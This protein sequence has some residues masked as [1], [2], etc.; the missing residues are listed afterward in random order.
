[1]SYVI[2]SPVR[3]EERHVE[4]TL[5]SVVGQTVRPALWLLVDD[6]ST[7]R[8]GDIIREYARQY[9]FIRTV[10]HPRAGMRRP[11][12]AVVHAF[13]YG[14]SF[15]GDEAYD[16]IVKLD[17]DL[18]FSSTYFESLLNKF[19]ADP[20]LGI[21]SGVYLELDRHAVW[22]RV[23]MPAYH[24][25]G[26]SKVIRR[27]CFED[28]GGFVSAPGWDTVDEIRAMHRGW[29]TAHFPHLE[30]RHHK[31]EGSGIGT[32]RTS[33]MHGEIY[34]VTGGDPLFFVLKVLHRLPAAPI[35][36]NACALAVGYASAALTNKPRLVTSSE[37][38]VY[39]RLL[40]RR[41]VN[42]GGAPV[43]GSGRQE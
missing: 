33:R 28:I 24:A 1:M 38:R 8:T 16:F 2:V 36:G 11:G 13:N 27:R 42:R 32:W 25:F 15:L 19:Q 43:F 17:C 18:S 6:G 41:L 20:S 4:L 31:P 3:D 10:S 21:A 12:A 26:A 22:R 29:T 14:V 35:V 30:V 7:D 37:A 23:P 34:Y 9:A 39:R 5:Q 40:R